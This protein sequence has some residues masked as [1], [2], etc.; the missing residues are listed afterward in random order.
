MDYF[1]IE[2]EA[3]YIKTMRLGKFQSLVKAFNFLAATERIATTPNEE[4]EC[5]TATAF[6]NLTIA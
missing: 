5:T 1:L 3:Y 2:F 4:F 6:R